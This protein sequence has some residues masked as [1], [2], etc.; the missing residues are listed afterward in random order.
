MAHARNSRSFRVPSRLGVIATAVA[1]CVAVAVSAHRGHAAEPSAAP[2][3]WADDLSPIAAS[4]WNYDRAAH[5]LERAGF[6]GPPEDIERLAKMTPR[7]AVDYFVD[8]ESIPEDFTPFEPSLAWDEGMYADADR[9]LEFFEG[10]RRGYD[11]G[12]L[13]GVKPAESGERPYQEYIV[14]SAFKIL[15]SGR[16]W[17]RMANWWTNRMV[18]TPRPLEEKMTLFWHGHFATEELKLYDYRLMFNQNKTFRRRATGN[19]RDM[20]VAMSQ[21]PAMLVYL[22]NRSN[23]KGHANENYAREIMEL[24][25]LGVGN[26]TEGDIQEAGRALTGW[27]NEGLRFIIDPTLHDDDPKTIFGKTGNF[28]G[29]DLVDLILEEE[30]CAEWV[31]RKIFR[32]FVREDLSPALNAELASVLRDNNYEL[33]PLLKAIFLS[34]DFYSQASVGTQI[35]SPFHYYVSAFRLLELDELPGT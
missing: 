20:L 1:L 34:R 3:E 30:A 17:Q 33:K 31:S 19:F 22:D 11:V 18:E 13:Y 14:K 25:A 21:D 32:F 27:R 23:V 8:Y 24:F 12:E 4:D 26:Y 15:G 9:H 35:T 5:L 2:A 28:D 7:Q 29:Y 16:E 10:I 6:S